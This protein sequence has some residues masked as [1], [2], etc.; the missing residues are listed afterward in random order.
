MLKGVRVHVNAVIS[1][2]MYG[3]ARVEAV[4]KTWEQVMVA[5]PYSLWILIS[6]AGAV[7]PSRY[8]AQMLPQSRV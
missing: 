1:I 6:E 5:P 7:R 2:N 8:P 3:N 4:N